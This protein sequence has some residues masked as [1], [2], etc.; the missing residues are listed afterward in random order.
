MLM[1]MQSLFNKCLL[2][3]K[4]P[5]KWNNVNLILI[6][7][8]KGKKEDI[9][10]YRPISLLSNIYKIFTKVLTVRL[11]NALDKLQPIEQAGFRQGFS[12]IDHIH[13]TRQ[14]IDKRME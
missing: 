6:Y 12:T 9:K 13:T 3:Q 14:I 7:K 10:N 8:G 11:T 5:Q 2:E 4:I 1:Y